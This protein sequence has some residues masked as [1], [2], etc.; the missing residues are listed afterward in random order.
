MDEVVAYVV[1]NDGVLKTVET[2]TDVPYKQIIESSGKKF[3][4]TKKN[5][6]RY[7]YP[8]KEHYITTLQEF[9]LNEK[10]L[11][12]EYLKKHTESG[13][14]LANSDTNDKYVKTL[15]C[16]VQYIDAVKKA[17]KIGTL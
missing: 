6:W 13:I 3:K 15:P 5:R 1:I 12:D 2:Y 16:Y 8:E 9:I 4:E 14:P 17:K 11:I 10:P 7:F